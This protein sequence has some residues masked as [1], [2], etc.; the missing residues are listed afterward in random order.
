MLRENFWLRSRIETGE[1]T[2]PRLIYIWG[3]SEFF[4]SVGGRELMRKFVDWAGRV[5]TGEKTYQRLIYIRGKSDF[6]KGVGVMRKFV[7]RWGFYRMFSE[8]YTDCVRRMGN[9]ACRK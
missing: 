1:K 2:Y 9:S 4:K 3:R 8:K 7:V 6:L 5:E